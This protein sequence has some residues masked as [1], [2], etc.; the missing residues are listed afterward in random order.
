MTFWLH[1]FRKLDVTKQ[2]HRKMLIDTF[3]N[4]IYLYDDKMLITF[5]Y[6]D[7]TKKIT[8]SEIQEASKRDASG[9]DLECSPAPNPRFTNCEPWVFCCNKNR[10][11]MKKACDPRR[12]FLVFRWC[13]FT[14][15]LADIHPADAGR[16]F[17]QLLHGQFNG[18]VA[19]AASW[20]YRFKPPEG[21][22]EIYPHSLPDRKGADARPLRAQSR[23]PLLPEKSSWPLSQ[24]A[25]GTWHCRFS[26]LLPLQ[27]K[28]APPLPKT[29][30]FLQSGRAHS[31]TPGSQCNGSAG[32]GKLPHPV[33]HAKTPEIFLYFFNR[34]KKPLLLLFSRPKP[35]FLSACS[36]FR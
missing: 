15:A 11:S 27:S 21:F 31:P 2:S 35:E 18:A 13:G 28:S 30:V 24:T 36:L 34:H 32:N 5:N 6:K 12:L 9:S 1:R 4:A 19:A 16:I 26:H 17:F 10:L 29:T 3:I 23:A 7:G 14:P 20:E 25:P 22:I 33:F 8:F